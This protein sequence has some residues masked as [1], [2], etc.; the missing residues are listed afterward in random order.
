MRKPLNT[1]VPEELISDIDQLVLKAKGSY[2]DRSHLVEQAIRAF[3][4]DELEDD[5]AAP[6]LTSEASNLYETSLF[7]RMR[8]NQKEKRAIAVK[9]A[10]LIEPRMTLFIDGS[11]TCIEL[12][13]ILA[14]QKKQLTIVTNSSLIC[15]EL[16]ITSE[17]KVIGIGGDFDPTSASFVGSLCEEA[18]QK[19]FVDLAVI[20]TKGLLP[21]DGTYESNMG[22]LRIKQLFARN[23]RKIML[24]VDHSKF[25]QRSLCKVLDIAQIQTLITDDQVPQ[26]DV[27]QLIQQGHEVL[28]VPV[29]PIK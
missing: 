20:S 12:A 27:N 21:N 1:S 11:T 17:H 8:M 9:A 24:L 26:D 16:G 3:M 15:L 6:R 18:A 19:Y 22:T 10:S 28:V 7:P 29:K 13:K 2:R 14:R 25:H 23:A 5:P 4:S